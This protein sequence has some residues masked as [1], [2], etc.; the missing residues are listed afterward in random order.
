MIE[1]REKFEEY[2]KNF[3]SGNFSKFVKKYYADDAIFEKTGYTIH[4][5]DNLADHF[6]NALSSVVKEEITLI[7][8]MEKDGLVSV[9]LQI[10]LTAIKDGFYIRDRKKGEKETFYDAGFYTVKN[11]K[12]AHARVYRRFCDEN[13][14]D[15]LKMYSK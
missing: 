5:A 11:D 13:T 8:Y 9:E 10:L 6:T 3:N 1:T 14:M 4:G 7:N 2:L 12:I 15:L